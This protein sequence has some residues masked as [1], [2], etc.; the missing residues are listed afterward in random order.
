MA[1]AVPVDTTCGGSAGSRSS[2]ARPVSRAT[3]AGSSSAP[4]SG[5]RCFISPN[6]PSPEKCTDTGP[7]F[8]ASVTVSNF[9]VSRSCNLSTLAV[10]R[11]GWPANGSSS[12]VVKIRTRTPSASSTS[13]A[14][15]STNVVSDRL[16]S[17]AIA[18]ICSVVRSAVFITTASG[19]PFSASSVNTSTTQ[20]SSNI[21]SAP[22]GLGLLALS[23]HR[24][25]IWHFDGQ[26]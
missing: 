3:S 24:L 4:N 14:R 2:M 15:R 13:A 5:S 7:T 26:P 25:W 8:S 10:P 11:V 1:K 9:I 22:A 17:R 19:L 16:N 12:S 6:R 18:C 23:R 21:A 20:Y